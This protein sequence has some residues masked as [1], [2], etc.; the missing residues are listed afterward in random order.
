MGLDGSDLILIR[1]AQ[2]WLGFYSSSLCLRI[3]VLGWSRATD[4][5]LEG[6]EPVLPEATKMIFIIPNRGLEESSLR[7]SES[8]WPPWP[9][10]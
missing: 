1:E 6:Q 9:L 2:N 3:R 4:I 5:T 7:D 10:E 8:V